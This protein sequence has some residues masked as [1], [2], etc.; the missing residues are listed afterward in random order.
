MA[1]LTAKLNE[2]TLGTRT[3][4]WDNL[5]LVN[6]KGESVSL[7]TAL[8]GVDRGGGFFHR[9]DNGKDILF[10][11]EGVDQ[12]SPTL[13]GGANEW[14]LPPYTGNDAPGTGDNILSPGQSRQWTT[15]DGVTQWLTR[16][17]SGI[18]KTV[19]MTNYF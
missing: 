18:Y 19:E 3:H 8:L 15:L 7:R 12:P 14:V 2:R 13:P 4:P 9:S 6:D 11:P 5:Y 10:D 16:T 17:M 1:L